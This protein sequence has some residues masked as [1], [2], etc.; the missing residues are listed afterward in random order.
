MDFQDFQQLYNLDNHIRSLIKET[1]ITQNF[2]FLERSDHFLFKEP[3]YVNYIIEDYTC[4]KQFFASF[5]TEYLNDKNFN[6]EKQIMILSPHETVNYDSR[7]NTKD[8]KLPLIIL[9]IQNTP[10]IEQISSQYI[11]RYETP[12][13]MYT[14]KNKTKEFIINQYKQIY[15]SKDPKYTR[16]LFRN[17]IFPTLYFDQVSSKQTV[18][19][20]IYQET[21]I[22]LQNLFQMFNTKL[23]LNRVLNKNYVIQIDSLIKQ[24][25]EQFKEI[26]DKFVFPFFYSI[27]YDINWTGYS[28]VTSTEKTKFN[29]QKQ[30]YEFDFTFT[31]IT[32]FNLSSTLLNIDIDLGVL[33]KNVEFSEIEMTADSVDW[34]NRTKIR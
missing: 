15:Y 25:N 24:Q 11:Y 13:F 32:R 27:N 22:E 1:I 4:I 9:K 30:Q 14:T 7:F 28:N 23:F 2:S 3:L 21:N 34:I 17:K 8:R 18:T 6:Q 29:L 10:Q 33:F 16:E 19:M 31:P 5:L 26:Q 20:E 12:Y